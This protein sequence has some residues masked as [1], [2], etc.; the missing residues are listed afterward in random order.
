MRSCL[1]RTRFGPHVYLHREC[2]GNTLSKRNTKP[3]DLYSDPVWPALWHVPCRGDATAYAKVNGG[4]YDFIVEKDNHKAIPTEQA[5]WDFLMSS[6]KKDWNLAVY[7]Q[8]WLH[9]EWEG[10]ESSVNIVSLD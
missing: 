7:E 5:F 9:N 10:A 8:D 6:S 4:Q 3:I 2:A 1:L